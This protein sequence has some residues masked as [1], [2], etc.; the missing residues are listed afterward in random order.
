MGQFLHVTAV[1]KQTPPRLPKS[2]GLHGCHCEAGHGKNPSLSSALVKEC[3]KF[4]HGRCY[5]FD[6]RNLNLVGARR[7][8][9]SR[10]RLELPVQLQED[11][12]SG[13]SSLARR[14]LL[15]RH[16]EQMIADSD[17]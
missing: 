7:S 8:C 1:G 5:G 2:L 14:L 12:Q 10:T 13:L 3:L 11:L 16:R 6:M 4:R 17:H 15:A 9:L